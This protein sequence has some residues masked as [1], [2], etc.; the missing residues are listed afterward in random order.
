MRV[1]GWL[2]KLTTRALA[3]SMDVP[4]MIQL[5]KRLLPNYDICERT[6]FPP[7]ISIPNK[8]V[9]SQIVKDIKDNELFLQFV[10]LLI[11]IGRTEFMGRKYKVPYLHTILGEIDKAGI[12]YDNDFKMFV[13]DPRVMKTKNWSVLREMQEY[14]FTFLRVDIV[15]SSVLVRKYPAELVQSTYADIR[16]IVQNAV[17]KRNGRIWNWEGDGGLIAFYFAQKNNSAALSAIEIVHELYIYNLIGH[18]LD[19]LLRVRMAVHSG[20]CKFR[21]NFGDIKSDTINK[22]SE[23]ESKYTKPNNVTFS[24]NV[25]HMLDPII[26]EQLVPVKTGKNSSF[27]KYELKWETE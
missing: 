18:R 21:H 9:A 15:G 24:T 16:T 12:F 13:E 19:E 5:T 27:F 11:E 20:Q 26:A 1:S 3:G 23:I 25:Y 4:T 10:D 22:V 14:I 8:T 6:G 17:E 7:N 2:M